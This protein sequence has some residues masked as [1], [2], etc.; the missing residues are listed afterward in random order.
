MITHFIEKN[1]NISQYELKEQ[2]NKLKEVTNRNIHDT[3]LENVKDKKK[4]G[5]TF[6]SNISR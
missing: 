1:K 3:I 6:I 5:E 2:I 4:K